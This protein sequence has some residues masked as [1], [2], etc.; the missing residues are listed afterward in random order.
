M[1]VGKMKIAEDR[2]QNK[3]QF[4]HIDTASSQTIAALCVAEFTTKSNVRIATTGADTYL[5]V[6]TATHTPV[7]GTGMFLIGGGEYHTV[8]NA[9]EWLGSVAEI[10]VT[11]LGDI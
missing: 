9:G 1:S 4:S 2:Y 5:T 3:L 10:N 6:E 8:I 11:N 7:A